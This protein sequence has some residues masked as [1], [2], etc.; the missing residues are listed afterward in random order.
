MP[1]LPQSTSPYAAREPAASDAPPPITSV[2]AAF[3][4]VAT[5][6]P[7]P[8][9]LRISCARATLLAAVACS[10]NSFSAAAKAA[11]RGAAAILPAPSVNAASTAA[12]VAPFVR[13]SDIALAVNSLSAS[14]LEIFSTVIGKPLA[15]NS[16]P[17]FPINSEPI[18]PGACVANPPPMPPTILPTGPATAVPAAAPPIAPKMAGTILAACSAVMYITP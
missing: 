16:F 3:V 13:D 18:S 7:K 1:I 12:V 9:S 6:C 8:R 4:P 17:T 2:P 14:R 11:L 10:P 15:C 5:F